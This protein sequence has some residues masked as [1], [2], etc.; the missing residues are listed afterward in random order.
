MALVA[1]Y[2]TPAR[3][4]YRL[5]E[6]Y[7]A[8]AYLTDSAAIDLARQQVVGENGYHLYLS[9]LQPD[10]TVEVAIRIWDTPRKPPAD[11]EGTLPVSIE[12]ETGILVVG[13]LTLGPAGE[14]TLPRPG[15]YEGHVSWT[16]RTATA[17]YYAETLRRIDTDWTTERIGEAWTQNPVP[18]QYILD[19]WFVRESEPDDE[20][21]E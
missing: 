20:D 16:G 17:E 19:L 12:S 9:S 4:N 7:D 13:Q 3:P 10:V 18:E 8:D 11:V 14:M 2:R 5:V 21:D 15:V 6:V 1:E